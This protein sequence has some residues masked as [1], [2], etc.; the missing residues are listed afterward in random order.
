MTRRTEQPDVVIVGGGISGA[1]AA[2]RL[3]AGGLSV[4]LLEKQD[5]YRDLVRGEW[6]A[7]WGIREAQRLGV[8][9]C[10]SAGGAWEIREW[11]TWDEAVT[12][13]EVEA[14]DMTRFI[15]GIGGPMSFPHHQVCELMAEQA[16]AGGA[17]LVMDAAK[18]GVRPGPEPVVTYRTPEGEHELRPRIV[19]GATGRGNTVG[20]QIGVTMRNS[21]H[22]W[23][24]GMMVEGLD[25]WPQDVQAMGTEGD[26]MFMVFPQGYGRA[27]L[28]LNFP[29]ANKHRY[30]G[31]GG[32]E[33]FLA[34]F[35]LDCLPDRG[36][37]VTAAIPAGPLSVW[38]SV[39]SVPE[40][41]PLT[42]G[43]VLIGDEAG[44]ADTV[45]GTGLSCAMR[46]ART[47]CDILLTSGDW[48]PAAFAPYVAERDFRLERLDFGASIV[49]RLHVE[50]GPAA[51]ERRRR[52]RRLMARNFAAQVTGLLNMVAPEDVPEFGFS[53]FFAERLFRETA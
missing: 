28:Y 8:Y 48:S 19:L 46:D 34:A 45:L 15:P 39:S 1:S 26:V 25:D 9:D 29:T 20:R 11:M 23:G 52:V 5:A 36:K 43:V 38:P 53:E 2:C 27:R 22:H 42:E 47:V 30:R 37:A 7:P 13:D 24:G 44:N 12:E 3:V 32:V 18:I 51:L 14:V 21:M 40:G 49:S 33:R 35:E 16:A 50:F 10:F 41:P 4:T 31:P 6:L 17:R